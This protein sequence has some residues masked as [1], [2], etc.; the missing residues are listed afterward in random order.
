MPSDPKNSDV[1]PQEGEVLK[2]RRATYEVLKLLGKGGFGAV[3]EIRVKDKPD[4]HY[5]A[6]FET[7][8]VKKPVLSMD[9][10]VLRG[11]YQIQSPHFCT[12]LDRGKALERFRYIV[13][14]L[15]GRNLWDLRMDQPTSRFTMS[16]SLKAAEQ[17]LI[18][19]EDL[20]RIGYLHRD[21]KPGNFA[22][23]RPETS[24]QQVVF[25]LDFGLCRKFVGETAE[26]DL[27][28]PREVAPFRGT[29]RY[30][31]LA[32]LKQQEQ[33][34][35]DDIEAWLYMV[36]EWTAGQLPWKKLK[37]PDKQEV[38][39]WKEAVRTDQLNDFLVLCPKREFKRIMDYVDS[40]KY[41]SIPDYDFVYYCI[42][43][44]CEVHN[45]NP[46]E[47]LDWDPLNKY[48]GPTK[49]DRDK[50]IRLVADDND[51]VDDDTVKEK[52]KSDKKLK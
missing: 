8:D 29:T 25:M 4:L 40:L 19:I 14:K 10:R 47:P 28:K 52:A 1:L 46:D 41:L 13:M 43:K 44:A 9:C 39:K 23:G 6:K 22:I 12:I 42:Q 50:R 49:A 24:E 11:A 18:A 5:A 2:S 51:Q 3:Y 48:T 31:P 33:S 38:C 21:I 32:A 36:V 7:Y 16:T 45:I 30:A 37:G 26:K 27:R 17:C 15:V 34:R 35:K 20:H